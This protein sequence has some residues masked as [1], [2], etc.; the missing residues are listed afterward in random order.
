M[1]VGKIVSDDCLRDFC[2]RSAPTIDWMRD[3]DVDLRSTVWPKKTSYPAPEYFLYHSDNSL[4]PHYAAK[5]KPAARGHRGY[6]PI[7][8]GRKAT[9]LGGSLF[10]PLRAAAEKKGMDVLDYTEVR[11]MITNRNGRVIG[12]RALQFADKET[13]QKY[14]KMMLQEQ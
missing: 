5:A 11:Q 10:E 4:V 1:E 7:E 12:V 2:E 14:H 8:Q 9:N 6:V 3:H 13:Q